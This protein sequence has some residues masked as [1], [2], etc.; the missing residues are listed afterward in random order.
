M[1]LFWL[2]C[3]L[4]IIYIPFSQQ[5]KFIMGYMIPVSVLAGSVLPVLLAG[6]ASLKRL[7]WLAA[8]ALFA[9]TNI[10]N[11]Q[12]DMELLLNN[13][14]LARF[15]PYMSR[16]ELDIIKW[17]DENA[18]P[19]DVVTAPPQL[20]LFIPGLTG[21]RVYYGHWSET[22]DYRQRAGE[23]AGMCSGGD[24]KGNIVILPSDGRK[25]REKAVF[26][27]DNFIVLQE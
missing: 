10:T 14:T 16:E 27:T 8:V 26:Q 1:L 21:K 15:A 6:A 9:V 12:K 7:A 13:Q 19:G 17:V 5:R 23:Y 24:L 18:S 25:D 11:M 4:A 3:Q 22:P 2:V 20:A